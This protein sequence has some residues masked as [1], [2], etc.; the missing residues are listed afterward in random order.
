MY[1]SSYARVWLKLARQSSEYF[2]VMNSVDTIL[3][4]GV[5]VK[6]IAKLS[7]V[8]IQRNTGSDL[9]EVVMSHT[10][11]VPFSF[12]VAHLR[13]LGNYVHVLP[14]TFRR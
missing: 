9:F 6:V 12:L 4:D 3:A 8:N 11:S 1:A 7:G 13:F 5:A 2:K 10:N 14:S